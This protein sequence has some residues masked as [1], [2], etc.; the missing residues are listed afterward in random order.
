MARLTRHTDRWSVLQSSSRVSVR[1]H[2]YFYATSLFMYEAGKQEH[3]EPCSQQHVRLTEVMFTS[4]A[5][6]LSSSL[7]CCCAAP[8]QREPF[9]SVLQ[10]QSCR[11]QKYTLVFVLFRLEMVTICNLVRNGYILRVYCN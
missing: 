10:R 2:V 4:L 6:L 5:L 7:S 3:P 8:S 11:D 1:L 9:A